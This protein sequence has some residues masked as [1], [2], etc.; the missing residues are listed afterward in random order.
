VPAG[1]AHD[2]GLGLPLDDLVVDGGSADH[3]GS[4]TDLGNSGE[5]G[6]QPSQTMSRTDRCWVSRLTT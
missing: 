5:E 6:D 1:P 3:A 4:V 2:G